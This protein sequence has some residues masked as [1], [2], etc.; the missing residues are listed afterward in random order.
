M[1]TRIPRW[2]THKVHNDRHYTHLV[3][4]MSRTDHVTGNMTKHGFRLDRDR[5][6]PPD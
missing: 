3:E 2:C 1:P 6:L 4:G 5:M